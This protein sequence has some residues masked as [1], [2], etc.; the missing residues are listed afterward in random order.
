MV[1]L[2]QHALCKG[3][4]P[5]SF[6]PVLWQIRHIGRSSSKETELKEHDTGIIAGVCESSDIGD[7][8]R[9]QTVFQ[10]QIIDF[11]HRGRPFR[12]P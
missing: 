5:S 9:G 2:H 3:S 4:C 12:L 1:P 6:P 7:F 11:R 10:R 8:S